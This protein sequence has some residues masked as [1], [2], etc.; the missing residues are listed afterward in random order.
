MGGGGG[1]LWL[2]N[3]GGGRALITVDDGGGGGGKN[4]QNIDYLICERPLSIRREK[5][6]FIVYLWNMRVIYPSATEQ[7]TDAHGYGKYVNCYI[8]TLIS[9][10]RHDEISKQ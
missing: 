7:R 6:I 3:M 8:S 10:T 2:R 1:K 9:S 5:D 4:C